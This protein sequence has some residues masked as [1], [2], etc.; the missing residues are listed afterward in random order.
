VIA[1]P[2]AGKDIGKETILAPL[3]P[4]IAI[5]LDDLVARLVN[6]PDRINR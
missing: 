6:N 3:Q 4:K 5:E 1:Q 2:I